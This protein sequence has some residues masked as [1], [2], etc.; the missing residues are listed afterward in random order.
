MLC[1]M[2]F[3]KGND[4]FEFENYPMFAG[5]KWPFFWYNFL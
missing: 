5:A 2:V 1:L 3:F 4:L